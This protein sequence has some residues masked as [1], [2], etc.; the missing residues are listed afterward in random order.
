MSV[1]RE[2]RH[3]YARAA[4]RARAAR[5]ELACVKATVRVSDASADDAN[6][7]VVAADVESDAL[8]RS[9]SSS[10][11]SDDDN[12]RQAES[13]RGAKSRRLKSPATRDA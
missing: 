6:D 4:P 3:R 11:S 2:K 5:C 7:T 8:A 9:S 1:T 13:N 12:G 10:T